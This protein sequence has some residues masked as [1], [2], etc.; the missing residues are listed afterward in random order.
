MNA[1]AIISVLGILT[2]PVQDGII[3][4][5]LFR[6]TSGHVYV[7]DW[8]TNPDLSKVPDSETVQNVTAG[9][10]S[11]EQAIEIL[12]SGKALVIHGLPD[13]QTALNVFGLVRCDK[14]GNVFTGGEE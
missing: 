8:W 7:A 2:Q 3:G 14:D 11:K 6:G 10:F 1:I 4:C 5:H 12:T 9:S 13:M